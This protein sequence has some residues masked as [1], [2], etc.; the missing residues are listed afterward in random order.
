[1]YEGITQPQPGDLLLCYDGTLLDKAIDAVEVLGMLRRHQKPPPGRPVYSHVAVYIGGGQCIEALGRGLVVTAAR[2]HRGRADVWTAN[3]GSARRERIVEKAQQMLEA[4][5]RY[6]YWD[7][8]VQFMWL[9]CGLR[10]PWHQEHSLIC[11]VFGYDV[12][13]TADLKIAKRRNCD[14]EDIAL[15]GVLFFKGRF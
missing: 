13:A 1:M 5:Y 10:I 14:P 15:D 9:V 12:W 6:S 7:I 3:I 11:S 8:V 4:G 2:T